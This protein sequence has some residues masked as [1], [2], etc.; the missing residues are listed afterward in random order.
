[1][2]LAIVRA[3]RT[4]TE[5]DA[6][7]THVSAQ[8]LPQVLGNIGSP[9]AVVHCREATVTRQEKLVF[10]VRSVSLRCRPKTSVHV[11]GAG[12]QKKTGKCQLLKRALYV[13]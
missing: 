8:V 4:K 12:A 3:A 13:R 7:R 10:H 5:Q 11:R 2:I 1:M 6:S 9:M